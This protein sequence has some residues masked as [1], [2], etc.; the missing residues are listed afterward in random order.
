MFVE[1]LGHL[2]V[3]ALEVLEQ[4][5]DPGAAILDTGDPQFREAGQGA[6]A[7]ETDDHVGDLAVAQHHPPEG[8]H[9][10]EAARACRLPPA[11][12]AIQW[13]WLACSTTGMPACSTSLQN[14]SNSGSAGERQPR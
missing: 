9:L 3:H 10:E 14:G 4:L 13:G 7:D 8:A 5:T 2:G 12:V 11:D 6:M 1:G